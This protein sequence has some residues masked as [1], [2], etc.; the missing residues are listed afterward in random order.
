MLTHFTDDAYEGLNCYRYF[1]LCLEELILGGVCP[2][3]RVCVYVSYALSFLNTDMAHAIE[4][5]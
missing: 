2:C 5:L 3:V 4:F 1:D